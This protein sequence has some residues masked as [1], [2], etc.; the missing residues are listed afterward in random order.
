MEASERSETNDSAQF[1]ASCCSGLISFAMA[2]AGSLL[3]ALPVCAE[4]EIHPCFGHDQGVTGTRLTGGLLLSLALSTFTSSPRPALGSQATA[5]LLAVL[6]GL[7][8]DPEI[9]SPWLLGSGSL[10]TVL[11]CLGLMASFWPPP[12]VATPSV[13]NNEAIAVRQ[14]PSRNSWRCC[15][16]HR[17]QRMVGNSNLTEALLSDRSEDENEHGDNVPDGPAAPETSRLVGT[18]RLLK[19]AAP[20]VFYLYLG[21]FV[22]LIRLPFSLSIPHF[23]STTL[24]ALGHGDYAGA[25]TNILL[26]FVLGTIDAALDFWCIFLFG[27]ARENIVRSLRVDTFRSILRQDVA[28]FDAHTSGELSSRLS[29]DCGEMAG[30]LTW[31]MRFAL[32]S[33]VRITGITV[34]MIVRCPM[35]GGCALCIVPVV[36]VVNK[37]YGNF[38]RKNAISVQTALAQANSVAQEAL[39]CVRTVIAFAAEDFEYNKYSEK[40]DDQYQ[41]KI[42]ELF[43]SGVYYMAISTF[44]INTCVQSVL[45]LI[46]AT[47]IEEGTLTP[48]ILLAFMLYQ[49]QLQN[50]TMNLFNSYSSLIKSSGAGDKVFLLLDRTPPPPGTG[51]PSVVHDSPPHPDE[52]HAQSSVQLQ[53]IQFSYPTRPSHRVL[54]G[55][56]VTIPAGST[57]ALVGPS[58]SGKSTVISLL[59]RFYDPNGGSV[60]LNNVDLRTINLQDHR[61]R[62]GVVTQDPILFSGSILSNLLYGCPNAT[63]DDAIGAAKMANAHDFIT[64]FPE[65]YETPVGERGVALSGGQKQ[66]IAIARAILKNP[67]LLLLDEATSALDSASERVVQEALDKLLSTNADMTTVVVAH[68]L[69]T[70]R[71]AD[72][73]AFI[74]HG[75]VVEQGNHEELMAIHD[76]HY[77]KMV[78]RAGNSGTLPEN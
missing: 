64:S 35:L 59:Q 57:L 51:N 19:L 38:L 3:F 5:G 76:G 7:L 52:I 55:L 36:A 60:L 56:D 1:Y 31:F 71:N 34:Y 70:V 69:Q 8:N 17:A 67:S 33:V 11:A 27:Y 40:I 15:G 45:L 48:E 58:G 13:D 74:E 6:T 66:R 10:V 50:E 26:L 49:G 53:N 41:L 44:L 25:R 14:E 42:R 61:R 4:L 77:K 32:E 46:G 68:R 54:K 18:Q 39:S 62:I 75:V 16:R 73:I 2:L 72:N 20:Q 9:A 37:T 22:L 47:L 21:C 63:S 23:V 29:S 78:D 24:G 28:F 43:L 65:G 12:P 30:D